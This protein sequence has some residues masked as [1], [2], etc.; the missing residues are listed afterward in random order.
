LENRG[1]ISLT[2]LKKASLPTA[3]ET[4][5]LYIACSASASPANELLR[6]VEV[7]TDAQ[8]AKILVKTVP[9]LYDA[10]SNNLVRT[11][12]DNAG[13]LS[14]R[15]Y[16]NNGN[17]IKLETLR[18]GDI[19]DVELYAYDLENRMTEWTKL[20][21]RADVAVSDAV[22]ARLAAPGSSGKVRSVTGYE[23][24]VLGNLVKE[25]DPRAYAFDAADA[26]NRALY[27]TTY[28]Y[29]ALNRLDRTQRIVTGNPVYSQVTYDEVGNR[30]SVRNERGYATDYTYDA[31]NRVLTV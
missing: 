24:D 21:D 28:T 3:A 26:A 7:M 13:S 16:D 6:L 30:K 18:D 19:F 15:S 20:L 14:T 25:I 17:L 11:V 8:G 23:Y 10:N 9:Y 27:T 31:M 1:K 29:D 22:A 4:L 5:L 2:L 12:S